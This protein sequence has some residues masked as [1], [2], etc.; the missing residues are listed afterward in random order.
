MK[1][2]I[3]ISADAAIN[4]ILGA[5][6]II[7]PVR[8]FEMLGV[9][10]PDNTFY[11]NILGA[12]LFGIGIAL[13]M[14]LGSKSGPL[15]GLGLAGALAINI[16]GSTALITWLIFGSL[17]I[18]PRGYVFLWSLAGIILLVSLLELINQIARKGSHTGT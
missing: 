3:L 11:A 4:L 8:I 15:S 12:V 10:L 18:P 13:I 5:L 1:D 16:C 9:P 14:E 6:L 17:Q 2:S 7:F